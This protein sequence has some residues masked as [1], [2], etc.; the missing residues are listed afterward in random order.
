[1]TATQRLGPEQ[2]EVQPVVARS[3]PCDG[4]VEPAVEDA[5][6]L[7]VTRHDPLVDADVQRRRS[8]ELLGKP[9]DVADAQRTGRSREPALRAGGELEDLACVGQQHPPGRGQLDVSAIADE[10]RR[11]QARLERLDLLRERRCRDAQPLG[12]SGEVKLLGDGDEVAK[13][14]Q[15]HGLNDTPGVSRRLTG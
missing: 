10:Q 3:G 13:Q 5:R 11:A 1:M 7:N 6:D 12:C 9:A 15:L 8:G 4:R 2:P 14:P